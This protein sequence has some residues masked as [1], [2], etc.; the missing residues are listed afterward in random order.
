MKY[1]LIFWNIPSYLIVLINTGLDTLDWHYFHCRDLCC[2]K[3]ESYL[4][5]PLMPSVVCLILSRTLCLYVPTRRWGVNDQVKALPIK[6]YICQEGKVSHG[7]RPV[8]I[9]TLRREVHKTT[10]LTGFISF[11]NE[12]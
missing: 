5:L 8:G 2:R 12:Q 6:F 10:C 1:T 4:L 11:S 9:W 7:G 3:P